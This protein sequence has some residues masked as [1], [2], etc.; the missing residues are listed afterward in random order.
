MT[1]PTEENLPPEPGSD[2]GV[3]A[4][5]SAS[6]VD[7]QDALRDLYGYLDGEITDERR[8]RIRE[9][10]EDCGPCLNAFDFEVDLRQLVAKT[11]QTEAPSSLRDRVA[12]AIHD[13]DEGA[14]AAGSAPA[15]SC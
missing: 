8:A 9:H 2:A 14:D 5:L 11:C 15:S 1:E 3:C 6:G 10:V 12:R 13:L 4:G 7:C